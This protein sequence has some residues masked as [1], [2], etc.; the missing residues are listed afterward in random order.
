MLILKEPS[1]KFSPESKFCFQKGINWHMSA[2]QHLPS[3]LNV[4]SKHSLPS[5]GHC[6][7]PSSLSMWYQDQNVLLQLQCKAEGYKGAIASQ[8]FKLYF[9]NYVL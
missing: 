4:A 9:Q 1:A 6:D 3:M 2:L 7:L 5:S 8:I